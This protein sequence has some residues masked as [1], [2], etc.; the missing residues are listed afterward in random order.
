[1]GGAKSTGFH[2]MYCKSQQN[3][4]RHGQNQ[5]WRIIF[6]IRPYELFIFQMTVKIRVA[7]DWTTKFSSALQSRP[8]THSTDVYTKAPASHVK[9][10]QRIQDSLDYYA[11][12]C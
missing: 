1:M 11:V 12:S 3:D 2:V 8:V 7:S 9:F 6:G 5:W 10:L 4:T